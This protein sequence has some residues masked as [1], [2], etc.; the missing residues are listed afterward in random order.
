MLVEEIRVV[1]FPICVEFEECFLAIW[2]FLGK[3]VY[4]CAEILREYLHRLSAKRIFSRYSVS[5]VT[6]R[7]WGR[8]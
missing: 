3:A 2:E 5:F 8:F 7:G 1:N 4:S 6:P